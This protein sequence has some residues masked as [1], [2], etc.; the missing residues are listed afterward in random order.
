MNKVSATNFFSTAR[1]KCGEG[2]QHAAKEVGGHKW[3][4]GAGLVN[5]LLIGGLGAA[6]LIL[7]GM[8]MDISTLADLEE[9]FGQDL[10]DFIKEN[11]QYLG[12][13]A[14]AGGVVISASAVAA[15]RGV[16][17]LRAPEEP[18]Q[19]IVIRRRE[20][21]LKK[22]KVKKKKR[23]TA[24]LSRTQLKKMKTY[25]TRLSHLDSRPATDSLDRSIERSFEKL[26]IS[27][28][29]AQLIRSSGSR[30]SKKKLEKLMATYESTKE[31]RMGVRTQMSSVLEELKSKRESH[32]TTAFATAE[33]ELSKPVTLDIED[34]SFEL[35]K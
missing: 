22:P 20:P 32:M 17:E 29:I 15:T 12:T 13:G 2:V 28:E 24:V 26:S 3:A 23:K 35:E 1:R 8:G 19:E 34:L 18:S 7:D 11:Q 9:H 5:A 10:S 33:L 25:T 31:A 16:Q 4:Y 30:A 21:A 6:V 14:V 27:K